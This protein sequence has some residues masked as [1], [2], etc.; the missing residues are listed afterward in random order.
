[1]RARQAGLNETHHASLQEARR[2]AAEA[3]QAEH[4]AVAKATAF[5]KV[6]FITAVLLCGISW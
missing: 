6:G 1:M 3:K 5:E 4:S 2:E